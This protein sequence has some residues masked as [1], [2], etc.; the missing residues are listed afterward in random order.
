MKYYLLSV[1]KNNLSCQQAYFKD[2]ESNQQFF[3][4]VKRSGRYE[5]EFVSGPQLDNM[6]TRLQHV[7]HDAPA[8]DK[9]LA[10]EEIKYIL[11]SYLVASEMRLQAWTVKYGKLDNVEAMIEDYQV[12]F[13]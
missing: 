6:A 8:R 1:H 7:S 2:L 4:Q 3:L 13:V 12:I 11:L 5:G 9:K 10:F